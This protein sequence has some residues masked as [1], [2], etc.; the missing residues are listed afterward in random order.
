MPDH[1]DALETRD[2]AARE[3]E[4][5]VASIHDEENMLGRD[6]I[7]DVLEVGHGDGLALQVLGVSVHRDYV[8]FALA[9]GESDPANRPGFCSAASR[10]SSTRPSE[11][12]RAP[13]VG[14]RQ[15]V[16]DT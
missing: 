1:Y 15:V 13:G 16:S 5:A 7:G 3:R 6:G 8:A 2:P 14:P 11:S 10:G 9:A 4:P 12:W